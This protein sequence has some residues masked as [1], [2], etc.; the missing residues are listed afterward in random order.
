MAQRRFTWRLEERMHE[1]GIH[2]ITALQRELVTHGIDLSSSQI[3]R[4][5]TQT[6]ERLNLEVLAALC[7]ILACTPTDLVD[8]HERGRRRATAGANVV[9]M[10]T[11]IRPKRAR[12]TRPKDTR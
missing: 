2:Q 6:P 5:V 9:D 10:A 8:V 7:E 4:L 3:H 11:T 12:V 1:R